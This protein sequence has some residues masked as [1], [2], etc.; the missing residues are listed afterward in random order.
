MPGGTELRPA[1]DREADLRV[2]GSGRRPRRGRVRRGT[3]AGSGEDM[4][5]SAAAAAAPLRWRRANGGWGPGGSAALIWGVG[6]AEHLAPGPPVF[7]C[8][9]GAASSQPF[10]WNGLRTSSLRARSDAVPVA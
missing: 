10:R 5:V 1:K 8:G 9:R 3:E 4:A 6:V 2:A 7:N